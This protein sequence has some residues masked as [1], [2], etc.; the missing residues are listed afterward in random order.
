MILATKKKH[1]IFSGNPQALSLFTMDLN[2]IDGKR[3]FIEL[4]ESNEVYK[5]VK[6]ENDEKND[7]LKSTK[8]NYDEDVKQIKLKEIDKQLE[9]LM[10]RRKKIEGE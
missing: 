10:K 7:L 9:E 5:L 1:S 6:L 2:T 4:S 8:D 3:A